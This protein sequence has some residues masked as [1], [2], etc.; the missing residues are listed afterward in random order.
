MSATQPF[1]R[2][3]LAALVT[4]HLAGVVALPAL[5]AGDDAEILAL[6]AEI[7]RLNEIAEARIDPSMSPRPQSIR[8]A[9][10]ASRSAKARAHFRSNSAAT[11]AR[12]FSCTGPPRK[13]RR[14]D[15]C[16]RTR[17]VKR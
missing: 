9:S 4:S 1:R 11:P 3:A 12:S 2:A 7:E 16:M 14:P 13:M 6:G 8:S 15:G 17:N 5:A 10:V